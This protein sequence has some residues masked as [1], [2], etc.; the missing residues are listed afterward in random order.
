MYQISKLAKKNLVRG[1]PNI[2]F[3]KDLTCDAC[4]LGKQV[5]SS[6]KSKDGISTKRPLEMLHIDLFGPTRTQSLGGKHYGLVVVDDYSRFGWVLFL[7][8]KNDAFHAFSTFC[9]RIQNEKDLKVAHLRSGHGKEFENQDFEKFCDDFGIAHNFSCPRTPQQNEVVER[10]NRSLQEMTR[11][12]LCENKIPKFLWAEV[13]NTACYILNRTL[14]RKGLK[15]TPYELWKETPPN[16]KYFH[17]F[18]CKCFVLNNKE[19]LSKF[20]P[21][22]YEGMFV[23]YSTAS[24]AYRIYLKEHRTIEESIHV[25]FC[26]SNLIPSTVIDNDSDGEEAGTSK[27][28]P[29]SAQNEESASPV[30]SRQIGGDISILSPEQARA[31]ETVRPPEDHQ[32]ST[33]V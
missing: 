15:K 9:K 31:T 11:A 25:T 32:S 10:R 30:L 18:G 33:P 14:I 4:Q 13:V 22:S 17:I 16:L 8:H 5:K 24:K 23:G 21:K 26:D 27:E 29:K 19:N 20:D 2:K 1:I 7:A 3:D 28:N 12:M 6:K